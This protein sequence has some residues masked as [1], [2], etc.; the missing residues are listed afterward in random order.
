MP[1]EE[2]LALDSV[3]G[4]AL[5]LARMTQ[6]G[7][8]VPPGV[9]LTTTAYLEHVRTNKIE[10]QIKELCIPEVVGRTISFDGAE[11][12]LTALFVCLCILLCNYV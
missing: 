12:N 8:P 2:E 1:L 6:V 3:G 5:S 9:V 10:V 4:K 7:L 11:Q